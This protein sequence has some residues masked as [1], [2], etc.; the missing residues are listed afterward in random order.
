MRILTPALLLALA[1]CG[2]AQANDDVKEFA[3]AL[4]KAYRSPAPSGV[5]FLI[6]LRHTGDLNL[7]AGE[8]EAAV[9]QASVPRSSDLASVV[10][11]LDR[12]RKAGDQVTLTRTDRE[13]VDMGQGVLEMKQEASFVIRHG[14]VRDLPKKTRGRLN[15]GGERYV[16]IGEIE[17]V[18]VGLSDLLLTPLQEFYYV[19]N[20]RTPVLV[21]RAGPKLVSFWKRVP[22]ARNPHAWRSGGLSSNLR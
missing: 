8:I 15:P 20:G 5:A 16:H 2:T 3:R 19:E 9:G 21:G 6:C 14:A 22:L 13:L 7:D 17:G 4:Q 12:I 11:A 10:L 1:L 18:R